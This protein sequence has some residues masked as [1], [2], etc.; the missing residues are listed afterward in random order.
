MS[1]STHTSHLGGKSFLSG[2]DVNQV[3]YSL[4]NVAR[5]ASFLNGLKNAQNDQPV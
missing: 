5:T 3:F 4:I 2:H 1:I